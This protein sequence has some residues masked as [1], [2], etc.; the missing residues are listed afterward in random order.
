MRV[1]TCI[2]VY[3][4]VRCVDT[5]CNVCVTRNA[6]MPLTGTVVTVRVALASVKEFLSI[7]AHLY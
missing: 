4:R 5:A 7:N 3:L 1:I 6:A 2:F